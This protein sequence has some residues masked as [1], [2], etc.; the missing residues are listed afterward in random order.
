MR[1]DEVTVQSSWI[2]DITSTGQ[3]ATMTTKAGKAYQVLDIGPEKAGEWINSPS[4][5][6]YYAQ[7]VK[8]Q[9]QINHIE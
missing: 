6:K 8:D 9:Y 4:K 3:H 7:N 2:K 1:I 5:G